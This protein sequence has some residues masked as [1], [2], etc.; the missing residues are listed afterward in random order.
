MTQL[1]TA[2]SGQKK[3]D[4]EMPVVDSGV[5]S[6]RQSKK[7]LLRISLVIYAALISLSLVVIFSVALAKQAQS[8]KEEWNN[9]QNDLYPETVYSDGCLPPLHYDDVFTDYDMTHPHPDQMDA[10]IENPQVFDDNHHLP[11][12]PEDETI[13]DTQ[14]EERMI[15]G[16]LNITHGQMIPGEFNIS[17]GQMIPGEFNISHGQMIPGEFNISNGQMVPGELNISHGQMIPGE[18]NISHGQMIP[19]EFN[20]SYGQMIPG[21]FNIS[22]G[23]MIPGEFN[24]SHGQMIPGEF[25]IS[26]GQMIPG[27]FNI[28]HGQMIPGESDI[29]EEKIMIPCE[30]NAPR[31]L[32]LY[33]FY[34]IMFDYLPKDAGYFMLAG[35]VIFQLLFLLYR[36]VTLTLVLLNKLSTDDKLYSACGLR[37]LYVALDTLAFSLTTAAVSMVTAGIV[38]TRTL[39]YFFHQESSGYSP[40]VAL[41]GG[42]MSC[43]FWMFAVVV[44][45]AHL[46]RERTQTRCSGTPKDTPL[47]PEKTPPDTTEGTPST[48]STDVACV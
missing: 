16:E 11:V 18:F 4:L 32:V 10:A 9:Y 34:V 28:S 6:T 41:L 13:P 2:I 14:Q 44:G 17:H 38:K 1:K 37:W 3:P 15:P 46:Y 19:G 31:P 48:W 12:Y 20:I 36:V 39:H 7:V 30:Y 33:D 24:I 27:E 47:I 42:W 25:N 5:G 35:A 29:P 22:H 40:K 43:V 21:E 45:V 26:H 23:Q 8:L